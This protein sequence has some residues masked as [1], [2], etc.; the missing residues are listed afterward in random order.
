VKC[1]IEA[2]PGVPDALPQE[3]RAMFERVRDAALIVGI[4]VLS[5]QSVLHS[6]QVIESEGARARAVVQR[7]SR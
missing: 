1:F 5:A 3:A 7:N 6:A 4:L 2:P